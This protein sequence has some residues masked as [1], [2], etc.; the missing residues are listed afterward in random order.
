MV[1]E[2][3]SDGNRL[4]RTTRSEV[5]WVHY[6]YRRP[7]VQIRSCAIDGVG[8]AA[9]PA[10]A[11]ARGGGGSRRRARV[12]EDQAGRGRGLGG[13]RETASRRQRD[14]A[15]QPD[16]ERQPVRAQALLHRPKDIGLPPRLHDHEVGG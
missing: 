6:F 4:L 11:P 1:R 7:D 9:M 2:Y 10:D 8:M 12:G 3:N 16:D 13:K 5:D 15:Q 14:V